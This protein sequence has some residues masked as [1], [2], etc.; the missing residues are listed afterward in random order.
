MTVETMKGIAKEQDAG[1]ICAVIDLER[2]FDRFEA[3]RYG[4]DT[5]NLLVSWPD[6][7]A[8]GERIA[9]NLKVSGACE[10]IVTVREDGTE[11][12]WLV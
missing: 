3:E 12:I 11:H 6:D 9:D 10:M 8:H 7:A 4:V 5:E 2:L 1:G